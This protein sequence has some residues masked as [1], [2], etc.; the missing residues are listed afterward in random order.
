LPTICAIA[1]RKVKRKL[2]YDVTRDCR[3]GY[4]EQRR[5]VCFSRVEVQLGYLQEAVV[6]RSS[7]TIELSV[8]TQPRQFLVAR[9]TEAASALPK[10]WAQSRHNL[11]GR[12]TQLIGTARH[13][14]AAGEARV[15]GQPRWGEA[16]RDRHPGQ[17]ALEMATLALSHRGLAGSVMV[18][19][20]HTFT[21]PGSNL[22]VPVSE[23]W[24]IA[25]GQYLSLP[26]VQ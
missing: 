11:Q 26:S 18:T 4:V 20:S 9:P 5:R 23:T 13:G 24:K 2:F 15:E 7:R 12:H 6:L 16:W 3:R 10:C 25:A 14:G 17:E 21:G 1:V 19:H 22:D 8:S